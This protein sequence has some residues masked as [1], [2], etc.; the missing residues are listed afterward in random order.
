MPM[1]CMN[2]EN[3]DVSLSIPR[4]KPS[5]GGVRPSVRKGHRRFAR[6]GLGERLPDARGLLRF[7]NFSHAVAGLLNKKDEPIEKDLQ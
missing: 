4:R 5:Q 6:K 1:R 7:P 3:F 2:R